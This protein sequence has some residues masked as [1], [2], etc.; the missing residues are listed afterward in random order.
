MLTLR[1]LLKQA[2]VSPIYRGWNFKGIEC[3]GDRAWQSLPTLT[4]PKL[5]SDDASAGPDMLFHTSGTT[6]GPKLVRYSVEDLGRVAELCAR[7]ARLEGVGRDSRVMVLLPMGLWTVGRIT[8]DGHRRAGA[9]VFPVDLHGGVAAW[10]HMAEQIRPTVIS[11]TPSVLSAWAL[12][13][14]G[15]RLELIETT[16][17]TLLHEERHR[18][19]AAFGA[20]VYDAYGLS[21]CV[22][23]SE[24][25]VRDGYHYWPDATGVEVL[26]PDCDQPVPEGEEGELVLTSFMQTRM[27]MLRYRSGDIGRVERAQC[28]CG[29]A[30]SRVHLS[31]RI[32]TSLNLPRAVKLDV[33]QLTQ[34]LQELEPGLRFRYKDMPGRP[35]APHLAGAFRPT[36]EI[37]GRLVRS[38]KRIEHR[39]WSALP[40]LAE[41]VHEGVVDLHW[42]E[43][44][45]RQHAASANL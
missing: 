12:H 10:Q 39:L 37:V 41:L 16:G 24:C 15:P 27:P 11:S 45:T 17:E 6:G 9:Q 22:V 33:N 30:Q 20:F 2:A 4:S 38:R 34:L 43:R 3:F 31:G 18:I 23:G 8:V 21:E 29:S 13:Y 36:I 5:R 7:F 19:E 44:S 40:E 32:A 28:A 14:R 1:Q 26:H 42:I 35:S 25:A